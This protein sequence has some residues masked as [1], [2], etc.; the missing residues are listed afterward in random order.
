MQIDYGQKMT[1]FEIDGKSI[2]IYGLLSKVN[3]NAFCF[4]VDKNRVW[5]KIIEQRFLIKSYITIYFH[6]ES[7]FLENF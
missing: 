5:T 4:K 7:S 6:Q 3:E 2:K 1:N